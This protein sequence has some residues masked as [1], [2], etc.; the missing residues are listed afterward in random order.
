MARIKNKNQIPLEQ[1]YW[2]LK[3]LHLFFKIFSQRHQPISQRTVGVINDSRILA[4]FMNLYGVWSTCIA[5][6]HFPKNKTSFSVREPVIVSEKRVHP[7]DSPTMITFGHTSIVM[8]FSWADFLVF[9]LDIYI[10]M[11]I[12][13]GQDKSQT[14]ISFHDI[15]RFDN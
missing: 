10:H 12:I 15:T 9:E 1:V 8:A 3:T 11:H 13:W 7:F 2:I 14:V 6:R 4:D 5:I